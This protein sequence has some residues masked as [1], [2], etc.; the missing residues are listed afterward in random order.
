MP[1]SSSGRHNITMIR[2]A[3]PE[4]DVLGE[5]PIWDVAVGGLWWVDIVGRGLRRFSPATGDVDI[6]DLP[7]PAG[8]VAPTE[9]GSLLLAVPSGFAWFDPVT[10]EFRHIV[11]PEPDRPGNRFNEG[12]CDRQG[13]FWAGSMDASE[14]ERTGALYRLGSDGTP[15]RVFDGLGIPNTLAWAADSRT[16]YFAETL[17]RTIYVFDYDPTTGTPSN[18]RVFVTIPG[19]GYPDGSTIDEG[20]YLWN[21]EWDG[22]RVVRYA[23]DGTVD[24]VVE[25]PVQRPTSCMFG[26][27]DLSTLFVTSASRD[28]DQ[29]QMAQQPDAGGLFAIETDT[30]GI[31]E[32]RFDSRLM[33]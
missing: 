30:R 12:K 10:N 18:R 23:P 19:P 4:R 2:V 22:W 24:R 15:H 33:V 21:A 5:G 9:S 32:T 20:G 25:M 26:G 29:D 14:Q 31:P 3:T 6:W 8:S 13:R 17:D 11:D 7:E 27:D 16:M 28:L 1:K